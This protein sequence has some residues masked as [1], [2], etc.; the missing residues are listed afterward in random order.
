MRNYKNFV[1]IVGYTAHLLWQRNPKIHSSKVIEQWFA[2]LQKECVQLFIRLH[3]PAL[4]LVFGG[5]E[6]ALRIQAKS[7][8]NRKE[9]SN[10]LQRTHETCRLIK[11]DRNNDLIL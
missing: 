8:V 4:Q 3:N 1:Q 10:T 7:G 5:R 11:I 6:T 9:I 2:P